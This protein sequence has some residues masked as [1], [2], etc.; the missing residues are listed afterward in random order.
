[1]TLVGWDTNGDGVFSGLDDDYL[2]VSGFNRSYGGFWDGYAYG[3]FSYGIATTVAPD[4][5]ISYGTAGDSGYGAYLS[6]IDNEIAGYNINTPD[7]IF[8]RASDYG[9]YYFQGP[10][11]SAYG[12]TQVGH[13][14]GHAYGIENV[15][16]S[17]SFFPSVKFEGP[18]LSIDL[19]DSYGKLSESDYWN[20]T[21]DAY[22]WMDPF[23]S[24]A[25]G[26]GQDS[27]SSY[28]YYSD[29]KLTIFVPP[30]Y[31]GDHYLEVHGKYSKNYEEHMPKFEDPN[32]IDPMPVY[33]F[34]T[35]NASFRYDG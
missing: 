25:L 9:D 28:G 6:A 24:D 35:V 33:D 5:S 2:A 17:D 19:Y 29:A 34:S 15:F 13:A 20:P 31:G 12:S 4:G 7:F 1:M 8:Q 30:N 23:L 3:S 16:D 14:Y 21:N 27:G 18:P 32:G 26:R 22:G 11:Y 10:N